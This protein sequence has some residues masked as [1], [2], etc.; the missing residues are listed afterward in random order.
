MNLKLKLILLISIP[1]ILSCKNIDSTLYVA[2]W[3][4]QNL[5]DTVDD[6]GKNDEEFT[7]GGR[8]Q[9][10]ENRLETKLNNMAKVIRE[11]N[12]GKGPD[13]IAFEEVEHKSLLEKLAKRVNDRSYQFVYFESPDKRGIDNGIMFDAGKLTLINSEKL[14][15]ELP[16]G[17]PTRDIIYAKFKLPD[18]EM[19]HIFANHWPSRRG[20]LEKSQPNRIAAANVLRSRVDE[21]LAKDR[22]ANI[23]ITGDFN[24]EPVNISIQRVLAANEFTCDNQLSPGLY[25]LS[26]AMDKEGKGTYMYRGNF[27]MLDQI[28]ISS[29]LKDGKGLE[30][31][32]GSFQIFKPDYVIQTRGKYKGAILPTYGGRTY[33]GGY[34]DHYPVVAKFK[35][36]RG[37]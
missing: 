29:S 36:V 2:N 6:P 11:M 8:L 3:N 37:E 16:S 35:I 33:L 17:Y 19:L 27:N 22:N 14:H 9:W 32:C 7:P 30:F 18:G 20:G 13:I 1:I 24:D 34:S 26:F 31:I 28:I 10:T 25:N 4:V 21:I 15:V 5:F 12:T 23:I